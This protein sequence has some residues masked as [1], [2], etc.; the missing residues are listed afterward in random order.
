MGIK[1]HK[2]NIVQY[3]LQVV[4]SENLLTEL[5]LEEEQS[6]QDHSQQISELANT[7]HLYKVG[8]CGS[9]CD[10]ALITVTRSCKG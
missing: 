7:L 3:H 10:H 1:Q 8:V 2:V 5:K 4:Q 9:S 6:R